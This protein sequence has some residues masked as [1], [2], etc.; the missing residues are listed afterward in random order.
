MHSRGVMQSNGE[1]VDPC[2]L[3]MIRV[4]GVMAFVGDNKMTDSTIFLGTLC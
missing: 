1:F 2:I 4:T 3:Q